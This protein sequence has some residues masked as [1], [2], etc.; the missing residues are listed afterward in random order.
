ML[1]LGDIAAEAHR[2]VGELTA[3][4]GVEVL[5][6]RGGLSEEIAAGAAAAGV[7]E[8]HRCD[9]HE[10]A[11]KILKEIVRPGDTILF[12]GSHSMAM[13]EIIKFL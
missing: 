6:T 5:L 4:A 1:E 10:A 7:R 8:I 2:R 11:G 13:D 3:K 12:K 9:T